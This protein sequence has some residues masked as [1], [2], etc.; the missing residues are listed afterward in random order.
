[1]KITHTLWCPKCYVETEQIAT[2]D[3]QIKNGIKQEVISQKVC[4]VCN[5]GGWDNEIIKSIKEI[6]TKLKERRKNENH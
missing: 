1:M 2:Y 3:Y 5:Y 4:L 6:E